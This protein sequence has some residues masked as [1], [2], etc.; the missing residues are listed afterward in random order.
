MRFKVLSSGCVFVTG[1]QTD[2][3]GI[4]YVAGTCL[5]STGLPVRTPN[6]L[7]LTLRDGGKV[8]DLV[9]IEAREGWQLCVIN[10]QD[11]KDWVSVGADGLM[12]MNGGG[13]HMDFQL[14]DKWLEVR[15]GSAV[16]T[17][18]TDATLAHASEG[19]EVVWS[20]C[21]DLLFFLNKEID[22]E[23]LRRRAG[24]ATIKKSELAAAREALVTAKQELTAAHQVTKEWRMV[25]D[26]LAGHWDRLYRY[27]RDMKL[28]WWAGSRRRAEHD[29]WG[30][31]FR[32]KPAGFT[33]VTIKK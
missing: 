14:Y 28:P 3:A 1:Y 19:I 2:I 26:D 31:L 6:S 13:C 33:K 27:W 9:I 23:E 4:R 11:N 29:G 15:I 8:M 12:E 17:T 18:D 16:F 20:D 5:A 7:T 10:K 32:G 25:Y 22:E 24:E 30:R 21:Q